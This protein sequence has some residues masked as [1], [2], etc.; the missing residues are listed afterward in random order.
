MELNHDLCYRALRTRDPRFDGRFYTG[1]TSTGVYCRPVCPARTPKSENCRFYACAAAAEAGGFRPCR[2]CRPDTVPGTPAWS[3]TSATVTRALR[4]IEQG[5][6]DH[7]GVEELAARL[8]VGDR[9]LRRLF[10]EHLGTAPLAVAGSR[11]AHFARQLLEDTAL[12]MGQVAL[13][14]GYHN[15][16]RF[17]AAVRKI[18]ERSPTE[19]RHGNRLSSPSNGH[20]VLRLTYR[21]PLDWTGLLAFLQPRAVPGVERVVEGVYQ[22]SFRHDDTVGT[23]TLGCDARARRVLLRV[24]VHAAPH[25]APLASRARL[26]ADLDAEPLT[27]ADFLGEQP[28]VGEAAMRWPGQ[29][30]P[31]AWDPF[32][33]AV[34]AIL[35][36]Q[37]TVAGAT[38]LAG[39]LVNQCGRPLPGAAPGEP[40]F[41][42]P[43]PAELATHDLSSLGLPSARAATLTTLAGAV[44]DD[45]TL[46]EPAADLDTAVRRLTALPGIGDWTAQYVAMRALRE[47][48][49]F[50]AGDL[51]LRKI[52]GGGDGPL[53]A[54][55]VTHMARSWRPWRAY[56]A[57][58]LWR[59]ASSPDEE[60]A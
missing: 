54:A 16:R 17:N 28:E 59:R 39:R 7:A 29:R 48:D 6:L 8:G 58:L 49:A 10:A 36:Q 30:V 50:P 32:E 46:L 34:R 18:F 22:R 9:H 51:V 2:R 4:L 44:A 47:P 21:E 26:L 53:S 56:A 14:A 20:L 13:A 33:T 12:P 3:G 37:V 60:S 55:A 25:L 5:A 35:G 57:M 43:T 19:L 40:A 52:L 11:R 31:G 41:L 1:V 23:L 38:R 45:P 24:P 27:I 42:F 15:T